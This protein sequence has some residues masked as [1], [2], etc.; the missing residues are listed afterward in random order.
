MLP[1]PGGRTP[2]KVPAPVYQFGDFRLDCGAFELLRNGRSL[3]VERKP[4]ELLILL[5]SRSGLL[6]TRTEIAERLWS[7][8]VF[9][10]TE[11]GINTAVGKLRQLLRDDPDSPKFIQTVTGMGYRFIGKV[12]S[13]QPDLVVPPAESS[14]ALDPGPA[15]NI[16][17]GPC[18]EAGSEALTAGLRRKP[19]QLFL[20][21][22]ASAVC[23]LAVAWLFRPHYPLPRITGATQLT[24]DGIPKW[25]ALATDG[26][27][28]Y[29]TEVLNRRLTIAA[30]PTTGGQAV[31]LNL[32][33]QAVLFGISPDKRDLLVGETE[34][35]LRDAPLWRVPIIGGTPRRLGNLAGHDASWSPDGKKLAYVVGSGL[36][37]A[38]ADGSDS[39]VLRGPKGDPDEW[40]WRPTWSPDGRRLQFVYYEM[41][42][43]K[44]HIWETNTDGSNP[45][46]RFAASS[47]VP[48][49]AFG[50]W[51]PDSEYY[52]FSSWR[53]MESGIP[54]PAANL[55]A[56]REK[57]GIFHRSSAS[58]AN[59]TTGPI[60]YFVHILSSD[61]KTIF[62][63]SSLKHG[64]LMRYDPLTKSFSPYF[65]GLSAEGVSFSRDGEWVA[66]VKY[67]QGELWRSRIDGS[68]P[69]QLSSR[70][71]FA[72]TPAWSPDGKQIAFNGVLVGE[73][74][75]SYLVSR[76]GGGFRRIDKI[77]EG[78]DP[79]WSP[80]GS[81]LVFMDDDHV[82]GGIRVLNLQT[83]SVVPVPA[84]KTLIVPR[85][86]P[87]GRWIVALSVDLQK[88][89]L[90]DMQTQAWRELAH[91]GSIEWPTWSRDSR[92][93]YFERVG[94]GP[95]IVR[96]AVNGGAPEVILSL[97]DFYTTG[98][99]PA[100]FSLTPNGEVLFLRDTG[101]GT[102][103]YALSWDA[104]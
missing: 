14:A 80:D 3:R 86:S 28:V 69:L 68:E 66:Y 101:G 42:T 41:V 17:R 71:L 81:S 61:G 40:A 19:A 25:G 24:A 70:P 44:S 74:S 84:S 30:V 87:D 23:L 56:L 79:T 100:W 57:T 1:S 32:P 46:V 11:H 48:M 22:A 95:E 7:S 29:F 94:P 60:R 47:D 93:I 49:Q 21:A 33:F 83:G 20:L 51:T 36:Y 27:R 58:P 13:A 62:A 65:P 73:L 82:N 5:V 53:E 78:L 59:L 10:D 26:M 91:A 72:S 50:D 52:V 92:Y 85:M 2:I 88:L 9:V 35:P 64:E 75:H 76:D 54:W 37:L 77:G 96:I 104:P 103:I 89:L 34:N 63:L 16:E 15:R 43:H 31:P 90:F 8:E 67:P 97:K 18:D 38:N 102:E 98:V 55:W 99:D 12:D 45:H 4:M 39:R 6:V